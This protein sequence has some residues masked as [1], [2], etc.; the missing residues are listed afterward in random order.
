MLNGWQI[1]ALLI[2]ELKLN[3]FS[4]FPPKIISVNQIIITYYIYS[5]P[6][7]LM[8]YNIRP[9]SVKHITVHSAVHTDTYSTVKYTAGLSSPFHLF[10]LQLDTFSSLHT[11]QVLAMKIIWSAF[12]HICQWHYKNDQKPEKGVSLSRIVNSVNCVI[13]LTWTFQA[14]GPTQNIRQFNF[15]ATFF[16]SFMDVPFHLYKGYR[17]GLGSKYR[18]QFINVC[19]CPGHVIY[20]RQGSNHV[21][22]FPFFQ[23]DTL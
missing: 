5:I 4:F 8:N 6:S 1:E 14:C 19:P 17:S 3:N 23:K 11:W 16:F 9:L 13:S 10:H 18:S 12:P 7:K 21:S 2:G 15:S 22:F 20:L